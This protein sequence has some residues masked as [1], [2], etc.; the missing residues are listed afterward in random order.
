MIE[1]SELKRKMRVEPTI[2]GNK[3]EVKQKKQGNRVYFA[4]NPTA[5][6][7]VKIFLDRQSVE[8]NQ[9]LIK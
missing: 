7:C 6:W 9:L 2:K 5:C 8:N 3:K 1:K 4:L